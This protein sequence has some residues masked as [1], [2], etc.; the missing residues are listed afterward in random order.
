VRTGSFRC[1]PR[2]HAKEKMNR[3]VEERGGTGVDDDSAVFRRRGRGGGIRGSVPKRPVNSS[4]EGIG[5]VRA[6]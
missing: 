5:V 4:M 6:L 1:R 2:S 3:N